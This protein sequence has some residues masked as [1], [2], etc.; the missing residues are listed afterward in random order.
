MLRIDKSTIPAGNGVFATEL[1]PAGARICTYNSEYLY[2]SDDKS[3]Q[4]S[5]IIGNSIASEINDSIRFEKM[6]RDET[7]AFFEQRTIPRWFPCNCMYE[8]V[9]N[10]VWVVATRDINAGEELFIDYGFRYWAHRILRAR[11]IDYSYPVTSFQY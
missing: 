9:E 6:T 5:N 8:T 10:I 2:P 7:A 11:L 1:I 4:S 3:D